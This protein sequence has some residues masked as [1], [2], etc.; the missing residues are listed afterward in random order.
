MATACDLLIRNAL[1]VTLDANDRIIAD[2]AIALRGD[3]I[4][5][6]G[7]TPEIARD[8]AARET[9]AGEPFLV[10]PGLVNTHCHTPLIVTRGMIEDLGFA[11]MYTKS[12]PQGHLLSEGETVAL[13]RLGMYEMLRSGCTT[14]VD[15]YRHP[16]ALAAAAEEVG[17][18]AVIAGRIHDIDL[19]A[20]TEKR[21]VHRPEIGAATLDETHDLIA[22]WN[23]RAG[24]RIRCDFAVHGTD[25]CTPPLLRRVAEAA[26]RHPGNVHIHLAHA[27]GEVDYVRARDGR[28]PVDLLDD[29]GLLDSRLVA[30][31]CVFLDD[32]ERARLARAGV[33]VAHAPHQNAPAGN[34]APIRELLDAGARITLCTDT[35]S[36]DLFEAMRLA[37]ASWRMRHGGYEPTARTLV[38]WAT[39]AGAGALGFE[40][41]TGRLE[42]GRKADLIMLDRRHPNLAPIIDGFGILAYSATATNV[43]TVIVDGQVRLREGRPVGFD[44]D[45]IVREAQKA[46]EAL[47]RRCHVTPVT[48]PR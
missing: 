30:A 18:R 2:G 29:V 33:S 6:V 17:V 43:D 38:H 21:M 41:E 10:L 4:V 23:G 31:H 16:T 7:A 19:E 5:A 15:F 26:G 46:A 45:A 44:G 36:G 14:V 1:I 37:M 13:A 42:V 24:G 22:R 12:V 35:R 39:T 47:W 28:S 48:L 34:S 9:I 11:P 3:R 20:L 27:R 40:A 32:I 25:T 8:R